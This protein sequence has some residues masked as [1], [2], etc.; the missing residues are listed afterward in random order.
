[1]F[2]KL[3]NK[4]HTVS[5]SKGIYFVK[6]TYKFPEFDI[7]FSYILTEYNINISRL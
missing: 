7:S 2:N 1:M 5:F 3:I 4:L 6:V